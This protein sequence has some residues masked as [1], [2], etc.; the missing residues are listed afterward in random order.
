MVKK[1]LPVR[2]VQFQG[3]RFFFFVLY[4]SRKVGRFL[5]PVRKTC[6]KAASPVEQKTNNKILINYRN[7][8]FLNII[9]FTLCF[10]LSKF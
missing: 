8:R 4:S 9:W 5:P 10:A 1:V 2:S 3:V 6:L 7:L